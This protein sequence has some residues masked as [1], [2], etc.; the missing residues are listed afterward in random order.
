MWVVNCMMGGAC[1]G[2]LRR[3]RVQARGREAEAPH[4]LIGPPVSAWLTDGPHHHDQSTRS[5]MPCCTQLVERAREWAARLGCAGDVQFVYSNASISLATMLASYPGAR[6]VGRV[7]L[8]PWGGGERMLRQPRCPH[9]VQ[10]RCCCCSPLRPTPP[11]PPTRASVL[12][13]HASFASMPNARPGPVRLVCLQ[14]P[15]PHFKRRFHKRRIFQPQLVQDIA[16]LLQPGGAHGARV[17][18]RAALSAARRQVGAV[19][20][21]CSSAPACLPSAAVSPQKCPTKC[22]FACT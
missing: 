13:I 1:P 22:A 17:R 21:P 15:D 5:R 10:A 3:G 12:I 11:P 14:F 8:L 2:K 18:E 20:Q 16:A 19:G 9:A 6:S 7:P 4:R